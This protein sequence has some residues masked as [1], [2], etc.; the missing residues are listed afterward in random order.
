VLPPMLR[1]PLPGVN[2]H[3]DRF[4]RPFRIPAQHCRPVPAS[5]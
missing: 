4:Y 2:Q 5:R 3:R 1:S